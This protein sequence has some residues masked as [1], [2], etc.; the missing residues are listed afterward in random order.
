MEEPLFKVIVRCGVLLPIALDPFPKPD[1]P[2][3]VNIVDLGP[4]SLDM[5]LKVRTSGFPHG[6][7]SLVIVTIDPFFK[8]V[9]RRSEGLEKL[10]ACE[11]R[12][13]SCEAL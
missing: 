12:M 8:L 1:V 7:H 13:Y 9:F 6:D 10:G 5:R 11:Y 3:L 4:E 2:Q